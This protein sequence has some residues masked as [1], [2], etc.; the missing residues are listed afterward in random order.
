MYNLLIILISVIYL[1]VQN[2]KRGI[3]TNVGL[4]K[5]CRVAIGEKKKKI[6]HFPIAFFIR[7]KKKVTQVFIFHVQWDNDLFNSRV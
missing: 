4:T 2:M 6:S 1:F 3:I 7:L 5:I